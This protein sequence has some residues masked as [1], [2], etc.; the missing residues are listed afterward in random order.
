MRQF[1]G[2]GSRVVCEGNGAAAGATA[3]DM[4]KAGGRKSLGNEAQYSVVEHERMCMSE[5]REIE[6]RKKLRGGQKV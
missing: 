3:V 4:I 5:A 2:L 6:Q 1:F